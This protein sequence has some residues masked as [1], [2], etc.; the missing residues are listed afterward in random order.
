MIYLFL[1]VVCF[2]VFNLRQSIALQLLLRVFYQQ[3]K[4]RAVVICN[5]DGA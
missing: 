2:R 5:F 1:I 4:A 3:P